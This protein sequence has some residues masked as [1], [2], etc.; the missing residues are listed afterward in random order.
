MV[1]LEL[2]YHRYIKLSTSH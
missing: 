1:N 2:E